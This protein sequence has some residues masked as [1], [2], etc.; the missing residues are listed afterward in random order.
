MEKLKT[1]IQFLVNLYKSKNLKKAEIYAKKIIRENS[2]VV[3]L[4]N[5]L[6]LI[7]HDQNKT[8]EA[9]DCFQRGVQINPDNIDVAL[10]YNNL[11]TLYFYRKNF[12]EAENCYK[13][14]IKINVKN[15]E[16]LNNLGNLFIAQNNYE[17]GIKYYKKAIEINKKFI[18]AHYNLAIVYKNTGDFVSSKKYLLNTIQINNKFFTAHRNLSEIIKYEKGNKHLEEMINLYKKDE[19]NKEKKTEIAFAIGKAYNDIKDY[20]T[21]F[22]YYNEGNNLRKKQVFFSKEKEAEEFN[23]IKKT[24]NEKYLKKIDIKNNDSSIIFIVGMPRSGTTL[25]EQIISSHSKVFG[26]DEISL[27]P[28]LIEKKFKKI[29]DIPNSNQDILKDLSDE[30]ISY[31]KKISNNSEKITDKLPVN[32]KWIGLIKSIFPKSK[33]IHCSRNPKDV[34]LSIYRNYFT[35]NKLNFAYNIDD[36]IFFY[37]LY[38]DLMTYWKKLI[39]NFI[40]NVVYEDLINDS[41]N[42]IREIIKSADLNWD[43]K[44]IKFYENNRPIRTA[45]DTQARKAIYKSSVNLW[46]NYEEKFI[47]HFEN[48]NI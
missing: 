37:N 26:G 29:P 33:V 3:F 18:A 16:A 2:K 9:I 38:S 28:E 17:E 45:S 31:L 14:S 8:D 23:L 5:I 11:G 19:I 25:V 48:L 30:Y 34:C 7:L 40:I 36:I 10:I 15:S 22:N 12:F 13:K 6:G 1:K 21:A 42:Q 4:Y 20:N 32:F 47:K 44:C 46:K 27:L 24:F 43:E 35:N 41:E 39:P